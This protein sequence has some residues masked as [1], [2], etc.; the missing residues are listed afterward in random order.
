MYTYEGTKASAF[1]NLNSAMGYLL[2]SNDHSKNKIMIEAIIKTA[3]TMLWLENL[4]IAAEQGDLEGMKNAKP[5][6]CS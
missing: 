2:C 4:M 5:N 1:R 6:S 3:E